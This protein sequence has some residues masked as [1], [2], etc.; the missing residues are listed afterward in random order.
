MN[1]MEAQVKTSRMLPGRISPLAMASARRLTAN[2]R[3]E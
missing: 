1:S 3:P 2:D